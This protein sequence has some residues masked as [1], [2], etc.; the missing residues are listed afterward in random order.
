MTEVLF[1]LGSAVGTVVAGLGVGVRVMVGTCVERTAV[2][3]RVGRGGAVVNGEVAALPAPVITGVPVVWTGITP[4][5]DV[6]GGDIWRARLS[7]APAGPD[8]G[9]VII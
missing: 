7:P 3:D 4:G 9:V 5:G 1:G 6:P 2:S 8:K